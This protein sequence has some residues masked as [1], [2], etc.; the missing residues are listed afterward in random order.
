M[1]KYLF[2]DSFD[3]NLLDKQDR[4]TAI[5]FRNYKIDIKKNLILTIKNY[6]KKKNI[7]FFLSNDIK[8]AINLGLDG[9]YV[10]SF[11]KSFEHLS[12]SLKS[13]FILLGS[14]HS[15]QEIQIKERQ[16]VRFI[17][18]SSLFKK[19]KNYLGINRFKIIAKKTGRR[20]VALG[21]ISKKNLK[22]LNLV[23]CC[24]FAGISF[25]E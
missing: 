11:N 10:P 7:K 19:N 20:V 3:T 6:C 17:F 2:I 13:N 4:N 8:L 1:K 9:A 22:Q 5:I 25:F 18:L 23:N 15:N 12:Y 24:G 16:K 14:A 21:G